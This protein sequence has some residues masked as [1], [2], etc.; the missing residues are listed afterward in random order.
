MIYLDNAATTW[1][2]PNAV[3]MAMGR[4][5]MDHG[6]NPG[7]GGHRMGLAAA[8]EV[9][10]CRETAANFFHAVDE[11]HVIFTTNC[12]M[13][14]N[15]AI[16]GILRGGGRALISSLEHN[17][18]LR[19]LHALSPH[20]PIY[21]VVPVTPGDDDAT[22][23]AFRSRITRLTRV[24]VC[25]H[26]SNV[27]GVR[28]PIRKI[29]E[30]AHRHGLLF[31][32]DAA[33]SAGLCP[34][35]MQRDNIDF[36]CVP[37]HKGLYGPMGTGMLICGDRFTLPPFMEG[38]T[39]SLS[40]QPDQPDELPDRLES[41]TL[42]VPG[43]CGLRAGMEFVS[44]HGI[45]TLAEQEMAHI[46]WM[47]ERLYNSEPIR[48]YLQ[49]DPAYTV[50]LLSLNIGEQHS[51]EVGTWLAGQDVAVRAGLHCA[52]L[53]HRQFGTLE[54]GTVRLAPS[55]FTTRAEMERTCKKLWEYV[56]ILRPPLQTAEN[57]VR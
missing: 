22:L 2:K 12:T 55:A 4:A 9:Y 53:A 1:P 31:V 7:R 15:M 23:Q 27:F 19:P 35:D 43:I 57:V 41:G 50:P 3:R 38:G 17:A 45:T 49:P 40:R 52:P 51:E 32:V 25:T 29:G 44:S 16:K 48:L 10:R 56:K 20:R 14:L 28:L 54:Q 46:R 18:V 8:E 26:A 39:G 24:I 13:A 33:Q 37:G 34:I 21:D 42:N 30:L 6:A 36:L 47:Y 5:L 11:T